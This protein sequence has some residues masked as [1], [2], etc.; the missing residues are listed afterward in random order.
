MPEKHSRP[1]AGGRAVWYTERLWRLARDLPV[2]LV[3]IA[4]IE[5][6]DEDAWFGASARPTCRA[7]ALHAK[8]ILDADLSYPIILSADGRLMDGGHR[9]AKAWLAGATDIRAVRFVVDPAPD[10]IA[11]L[12]SS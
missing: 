7:V 2:E 5:E 12:E 3:A 11:P 8:R 1:I 9:L 10:Y 4:A 6:F